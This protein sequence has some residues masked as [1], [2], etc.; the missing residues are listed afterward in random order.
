MTIEVEKIL[1]ITLTEQQAQDLFRYLEVHEKDMTY[2]GPI[3]SLR[4]LYKDLEEIV[5]YLK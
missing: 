2:D 4:R 1:R 3:T 5:G